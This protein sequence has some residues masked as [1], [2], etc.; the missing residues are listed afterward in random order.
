MPASRL[1]GFSARRKKGSAEGSAEAERR[2]KDRF[3]GQRN[4]HPTR[5]P[6]IKLYLLAPLPDPSSGKVGGRGL[7]PRACRP[8]AERLNTVPGGGPGPIGGPR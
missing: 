8:G 1:T 2:R 3:T 7:G 5:I 4:P 6:E